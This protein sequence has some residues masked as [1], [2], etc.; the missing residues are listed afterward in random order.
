MFPLNGRLCGRL[1]EIISDQ[2]YFCSFYDRPKSDASTSYYYVDDDVHY[3]SFYSDFG[4]LNLSV[5]YRFCIKLDEKLKS[6]A[7]KKR[8]VV[9]SGSSDEARVNAAY[10]VGAFCIIYLGVTAEIAYLRLHK[11]EP[12]GFIGFRD[13]AMGAPTYRLHLHNVLRGVEKAVKLKWVSFDNFDPDEY[14]F[15]ERVENGD[16]NWIIPNKVLSFC[17][18]HNKSVVENGYPYHAP[19]VYFDYFRRHNV[20]TIIR[21]NKRMYDA[22][23][24]VDAGFDHIDLFFVDGSTPSDE[25]V[26]RF[27]SVIDSAKGAV[28]VH[29]KAGLGR[30]GTLIACWMMKE[31]GVT[32]A[33]SMA[34]LRICRPGS[35]IGPQQQ[36][37]IEKQP[38][39]W[40]LAT[41][42]TSSGTSHLSQLTSKVDEICICDVKKSSPLVRPIA[43]PKKIRRSSES[44]DETSVD[45]LGRTQGDRLLA[46]KVKAQHHLGGTKFSS[47]TTPIKPMVVSQPKPTAGHARRLLQCTVGHIPNPVPTSVDALGRTQAIVRLAMKVKAQHHLG[48]TKFSSPTTP[49]KPMVVSQ[50]KPT[51][52]HARRL[53]Q[54]TVG[55]IP[56]PVPISRVTVSSTCARPANVK[57]KSSKRH[58]GVRS[59]PYPPAGVKIQMPASGYELRPRHTFNTSQLRDLAKTLPPNSEALIGKR[60][61]VSTR[62][63]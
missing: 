13:A 58:V 14:E 27:I 57:S 50:P 31:Y 10:L 24:F 53:L 49:I 17:G 36:F 9:C 2:L 8:I 54:C 3:D 46:M 63:P 62:S 28:A 38:W 37:L 29:C 12:G 7:G 52:G 18:P 42:R 6:L 44:A 32:A 19:E 26:Q 23:R 20:S 40:A 59:K 16:F 56:N 48:G 43:L 55:H 15:Y 35:V 11:A 5:L 41:A 60:R 39:C 21:L 47:P 45:A 61:N 4:P 51:A 1:A 33:E 22:K 34:W 25:I 30:T